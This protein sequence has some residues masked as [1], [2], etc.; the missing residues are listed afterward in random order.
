VKDYFNQI[1]PL[2]RGT[3]IVP[4]PKEEPPKPKIKPFLKINK[5]FDIDQDYT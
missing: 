1:K 4:L 5:I 2:D 3:K